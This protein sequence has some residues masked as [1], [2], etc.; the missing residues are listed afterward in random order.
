MV[1][2][3]TIGVP[4]VCD[5][6]GWENAKAVRV[7]GIF[8][9]IGGLGMMI[10]YY[11]SGPLSKRYSEELV[12]IV[13]GVVP[14]LIG[15][16]LFLPI[17]DND[18]AMETCIADTTT[19]ASTG[20]SESGGYFSYYILNGDRQD[21]SLIADIRGLV[22]RKYTTEATVNSTFDEATSKEVT[23][24]SLRLQLTTESS[25]S[26]DY[27]TCSPGCPEIQ[28]W[29]LTVPMLVLPQFLLAGVFIMVG[30]PMT[31][32]MGLGLYA[33]LIRSKK[34]GLWMA[35]VSLVGSGSRIVGPVIVSYIYTNYGTYWTFGMLS[36]LMSTLLIA[37]LLFRNKIKLG[38]S[39]CS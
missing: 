6:Y 28:N 20:I 26:T 13:G 19:T 4:F 8:I 21:N 32:S 38:T 12:L 3:E 5:Q 10:L 9:S 37:V 15:C 30:F 34:Q 31:Q 39:D 22:F 23:T 7:I 33:K 36:G 29:C 17:G 24:N 14:M 18:I 16:L 11:I 27:L 35:L 2:L 1:F 25:P